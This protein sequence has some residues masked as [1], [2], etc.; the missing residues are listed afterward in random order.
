MGDPFMLSFTVLTNDGSSLQCVGTWTNWYDAHDNQLGTK[1]ALGQAITYAYDGFDRL[2][3]VTNALQQV[4]RMAYD[5]RGNLTNLLDSL[6]RAT[7]W[8]YD[9]NGRNYETLYAD[10]LRIS[11]GYDAVGRLAA[12]TNDGSGLWLH[13]NYDDLNRLRDVIFP[14]GT[15]NHFEYS[16]CGLDYTRDRLGRSTVYGRDALGRTTSITDP[17]NRVTGFAYNGADQITRLTTTV[18]GLARVKKFDYTST[19]GFSRLTKVT[20]PMGKL[21][22]Y[23]YTFRGGLAWRQNGNGNVM[24]YQYDPLQ[25]LVTVT[26][27]ND[28]V[29]VSMNYDIGDNVTHVASTNSIFDYAYD[30]LNRV[31]NMVCVLTNIPGFATV[32]YRIDYAFDGAGNMTNRLIE[33]IRGFADIIETR[34]NYDVMNRLTNVVQLTNGAVSA[35]AWYAYDTAGR[36]WQKGYGN[37]D[38]VTHRYDI[39][40]RLLALG[41]TNGTTLVQAYI[42]QWDTAGNILAITN[43]DGANV[44]VDRYGYDAAGQLTNEICITNGIAGGATNFWVYDE[45]GN[46]FTGDGKYRLY[47]G[48]NEFLGISD[49]RTNRVTV[50]GEVDAG[51]ASNKW[52]NT[53]VE[54][55]NVRA[56]VSHTDGT[57][58]LPNVPLYP[59]DND[60]TVTVTD[61][62]G[63]QSQQTRHVTKNCTESFVYDGNGNLTNWINGDQNWKYQWDW[64]DRLVKVT[65]NGVV[66]LENWY[67]ALGRRIAKNEAVNG[68]VKSNLYVLDGWASEAVLDQTAQTLETFTRGVGLG[69]DIGTLVGVTHHTG[70]AMVPATYFLQNNNRGDVVLVR[71]GASTVGSYAYSA[72][73]VLTA[74]S[75]PYA[76]RFKFSSKEIEESCGLIYYGYRFYAP[77]WQ[78][79]LN[80]DPLTDFGSLPSFLSVEGAAFKLLRNSANFEMILGPN[81][82]NFGYNC[83]IRNIDPVGLSCCSDLISCTTATITAVTACSSSKNPY[84]CWLAVINAANACAKAVDSCGKYFEPPPDF[85]GRPIRPPPW[86]LH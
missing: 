44:V 1:N 17:E 76:C 24:K 39:E 75:C 28:A 82:F 15:S 85:W 56:Q 58:S 83:P 23:D 60:L 26:D 29:L 49:N 37:G 61:V 54:C 9:A 84:A 27:G 14:D 12:L 30:T 65:S 3:S 50:T 5:D 11:K 55:R 25:Q 38:V 22:Q 78:R 52:Y 33:G 6:N 86:G 59:G 43:D 77:K 73:G 19:N 80:R 16:C 4:N 31:T 45:A 69:A 42:Y 40:G 62:S 79:W 53:W 71:S 21:T 8:T 10:G 2:T 57:F 48:D 64:A 41:I 74:A 18:N 47:N 34:Y 72:F 66:V 81:L 46:W 20:T 68:L 32:E 7:R 67:D 36:L 70:G 51:P 13:Y 63:N 35:S